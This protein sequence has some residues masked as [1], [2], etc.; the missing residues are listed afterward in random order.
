MFVLIIGSH[1]FGVS[2]TRT[3][4]DVKN[5]P[6]SIRPRFNQSYSLKLRKMENLYP[7]LLRCVRGIGTH[8]ECDYLIYKRLKRD[9]QGISCLLE[10]QLPSRRVKSMGFGELFNERVRRFGKGY[11]PPLEK[12]VEDGMVDQLESIYGDHG[13]VLPPEIPLAEVIRDVEDYFI[14]DINFI[15]EVDEVVNGYEE[16]IHDLEVK[17][18]EAQAALIQAETC[19]AQ[20]ENTNLSVGSG[21]MVKYDRNIKLKGNRSSP[22]KEKAV[23]LDQIADLLFYYTGIK[24]DSI[25]HIKQYVCSLATGIR[26]LEHTRNTCET[27]RVAHDQATRAYNDLNKKYTQSNSDHAA[28]LKYICEKL[29][30]VPSRRLINKK[31]DYLRKEVFEK[32][33]SVKEREAQYKAHINFLTRLLG[34]Y[35]NAERGLKCS[36]TQDD[37]SFLSGLADSILSEDRGGGKPYY[38]VDLP[39]AAEEQKL[40]GDDGTIQYQPYN[41]ADMGGYGLNT[42]FTTLTEPVGFLGTRNRGNGYR[43]NNTGVNMNNHS[44]QQPVNSGSGFRAP[45]GNGFNVPSGNTYNISGGQRFNPSGGNGGNLQSNLGGNGYSQP[46]SGGNIPTGNYYQPSRGNLNANVGGRGYGPTTTYTVGDV[47]RSGRGRG[48]NKRKRGKG[49][50]W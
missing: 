31:L 29:L 1:L 30:G 9:L 40:D 37:A 7:R 33:I 49:K 39:G 15:E 46:L 28:T 17:L 38:I 35:V 24:F 19:A 6:I 25:D 36:W 50:G 16:K 43:G 21:A 23:A 3:L 11:T 22:Y 18:G 44:M 12:V 41:A 48:R 45:N 10:P 26:E 14:A 47:L 34:M 32:T 20:G 27:I 5:Y 13:K 4:R 2:L 42:P 8:I